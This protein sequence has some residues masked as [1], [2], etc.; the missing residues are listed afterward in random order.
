MVRA[1][2]S[3]EGIPR[4]G[5]VNP[6]SAQPVPADSVVFVWRRAGAEASYRL[7]VTDPAGGQMWTTATADTVAPLP[8]S[9]RLARG[10][11]YFWYVDALLPTGESATTGVQEFRT[12]P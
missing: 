4:F 3:P 11:A 6:S 1:G 9:V 2:S 7:T 8:A 10:Q 5:T 12:A